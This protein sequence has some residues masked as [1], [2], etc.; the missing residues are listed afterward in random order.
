MAR[1]SNT[2]APVVLGY[3]RIGADRVVLGTDYPFEMGDRR[4][5]ETVQT[6]PALDADQ[7]GLILEGNIERILGQ[8]RR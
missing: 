6:I 3:G 1:R 4:P 5:V 7:R 8:I 2:S